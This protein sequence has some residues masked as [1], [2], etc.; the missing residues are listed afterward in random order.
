M[1]ELRAWRIGCSGFHYPEWK[2]TFYPEGLAKRKWFEHYCSVFNT[3]ELNATFYRYPKVET[4][5][6]WHL[7]SPSNFRFSVKVPRHITHYRKLVNTEQQLKLF[8][9]TVSEGLGEKLGCVLFQLSPLMKYTEENLELLVRAIDASFMNAVEFRHPSWWNR[10]VYQTLRRNKIIFCSISHPSL[11][12]DIITTHDVA[13]FRFH[14]SPVLYRSKYKLNELRR[15]YNHLVTAGEH[16]EAY[17]YFNNTASG[18]AISNAKAFMR[19][20]HAGAALPAAM[21]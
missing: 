4:L 19:V 1:N 18:A 7:R 17:V 15:V 13:Y 20:A 16:K 14:G 2:E 12:A 8:Y 21:N 3:L 5:K 10:Q 9:G 11:P 6:S